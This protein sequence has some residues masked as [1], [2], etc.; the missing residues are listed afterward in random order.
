MFC[1]SVSLI[2]QKAPVISSNN[3]MSQEPGLFL[4]SCGSLRSAT[5]NLVVSLLPAKLTSQFPR[6]LHNAFTTPSYS[7]LLKFNELQPTVG[8]FPVLLRA[9]KPVNLRWA[10]CLEE[11]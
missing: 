4:P 7:H 6:R 11:Y 5:S 2:S 3:T 9:R 1:Y 10:C 8:A